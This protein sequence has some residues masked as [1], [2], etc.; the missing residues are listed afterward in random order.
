MV[1]EV[2]KRW[3]CCPPLFF[4][5][6]RA[7][8]RM[9]TRFP[10]LDQDGEWR[11][12]PAARTSPLR[13]IEDQRCIQPTFQRL[14]CRFQVRFGFQG[15]D[16][17]RASRRTLILAGPRVVPGPD[18]DHAADFKCDGSGPPR[19]RDQLLICSITARRSAFKRR[20]SCCP[21]DPFASAFTIAISNRS[22][23][24]RNRLKSLSAIAHPSRRSRERA[25]DTISSKLVGPGASG[26]RLRTGRSSIGDASQAHEARIACFT[27]GSN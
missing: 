6:Q 27:S 21:A 4:G 3:H 11:L 2:P 25:A 7:S 12:P 23:S 1:Q 9:I 22:S 10:A 20:T 19:S 8:G 16:L 18:D 17:A 14:D 13:R 24:L 26:G 5:K 15:S